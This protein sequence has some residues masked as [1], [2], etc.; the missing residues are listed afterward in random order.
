MVGRKFKVQNRSQIWNF[1]TKLKKKIK[2][3]QNY[4]K[5]YNTKFE[6]Y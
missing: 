3:L 4:F 2:L 5:D 6:L 1:S